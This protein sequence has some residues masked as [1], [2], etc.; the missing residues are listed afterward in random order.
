MLELRQFVTTRIKSDGMESFVVRPLDRSQLHAAYPLIRQA[1]PSVDLNDWRRFARR[2]ADP[3]SASRHGV[4]V[5][6]R[7]NAPH[8]SGLFCYAREQ[9]LRHG[10][11][12]SANY[13]VVLD[14]FDPGAVFEALI[15]ALEGLGRQLN[16]GM[17]RCAPTGIAADGANRFLAAGHR[18]EGAVYCKPIVMRTTN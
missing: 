1:A 7:T 10:S 11:I 12:L 8:P 16:C 2:A 3:R 18:L 17:V 15:D 14:M 4:I 13:F 6:H 5:A 9:D